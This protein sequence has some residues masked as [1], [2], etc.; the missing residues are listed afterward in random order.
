MYLFD[1]CKRRGDESKEVIR[2]HPFL[3]AEQEGNIASW[4]T[5]LTQI[6][7]DFLHFP[8]QSEV[9][10]Q[11]FQSVFLKQ[12]EVKL[13]LVLAILHTSLHYLTLGLTQS[14]QQIS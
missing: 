8:S 6:A 9:Y 2:S 12:S 5:V 10:L 3:E 13:L 1:V 4:Q 11:H 14:R 7:F